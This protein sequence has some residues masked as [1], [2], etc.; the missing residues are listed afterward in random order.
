M[1]IIGRRQPS[2]RPPWPTPRPSAGQA[3]LDRAL[4]LVARR[5]TPTA[6][7]SLAAG[8]SAT[9]TPSE[10]Q[11]NPIYTVQRGRHL[12][13]HADGDRR[14]RRHRHRHG[15]RRTSRPIPNVPP[16]AAASATPTS[17]KQPLHRR[18]SRPPAR[19]TPTA[20]SLSLRLGLRRRRHVRRAANPSHTYP[21]AGNFL[22]SLTVTDNAGGHDTAAVPITRRP[23]PSADRGRRRPRR[24]P[25]KQTC[26]VTFS[27]S[28]SND[29]DG[30][31]L[32]CHWDFGDG[33]S[34]DTAGATAHATPSP[35]TTS[36]R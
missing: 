31:I 35:G 30:T 19:A 18:R 5:S 27:S 7:S 8:T 2:R 29:S 34:A 17:G 9:A 28:L 23:E 21:N 15:R 6:R 3:P 22:A 14:Q 26:S 20:R 4:R 32:S 11:P 10:R 1:T 36:P 12:H 13:R 24:S 33:G 25:G 16:S